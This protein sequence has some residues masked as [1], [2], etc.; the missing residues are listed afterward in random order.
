MHSDQTNNTT[1]TDNIFT[2]STSILSK[3]NFNLLAIIFFINIHYVFRN[4]TLPGFSEKRKTLN[5]LSILINSFNFF[6]WKL[7][8]V[9]EG[10]NLCGVTQHE[11]HGVEQKSP[12]TTFCYNNC[13]LGISYFL[14]GAWE[15]G[16]LTEELFKFRTSVHS[17]C[18][19]LYLT[20]VK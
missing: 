2:I 13:T 1:W 12:S 7:N 10:M 20:I 14:L 17:F 9:G 6:I 3:L 15:R 11:Y 18:P 4:S 8:S 16:R 5:V 19:S